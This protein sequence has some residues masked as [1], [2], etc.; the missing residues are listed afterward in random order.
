[1]RYLP[2]IAAM[3]CFEAAAR[4]LSFTRAADELSLTQSA[5]S[6]QVA[7]LESFLSRKLFRRVR[8][9]LCL[10][11]EGAIYIGEVRKILAQLEMSSQY[12]MSYNNHLDVLK[13]ATLPTFG[14]RWLAP[15][16]SAF[17][18][19]HPHISLDCCEQ[20]EPFDLDKEG[21]DIAFFY[22]HGSWPGLE[23]HRLFDEEVVPV[24]APSLLDGQAPD[25][26][27][28]LTRYRL[29]HLSTRPQAWH[30]WFA[31]Q[32]LTTEHS[33]QGN[34]FET[35]HMLIRATMAGTGIALLPRFLIE[36]ELS[37]GEL[38]MPWPHTLL[39]ANGYY[40]AYPERLGEVEKVRLFADHLL[41][42]VGERQIPPIRHE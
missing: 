41:H 19:A 35:F 42:S 6:K 21:I 38:L 32:S 5:V 11:P 26:P 2:S 10:T 3:Q 12:V 30:D 13:I 40:L 16:L 37:R 18:D 14:S 33:Y 25:S 7:Q 34:R 24:C 4:H 20:V 29:L 36:D 1:M 27:L 31:S 23:C 28:D 22:G 15:Q 8:R 39:S 17:L 9:S